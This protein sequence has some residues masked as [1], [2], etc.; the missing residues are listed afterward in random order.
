MGPYRLEALLG[1]GAMG[2]VY[3]ATDGRVG[4]AVALK[5]PLAKAESKVRERLQREGLAAASLDHPHVLKVHDLGC[6]PE[7][8]WYLA[9]ELV[10][11]ARSFE[12]AALELPLRRRVELVRDAA[13]G[14]GHAHARGVVHRDVKADNL[15]LDAAG[16][17][18]VADFGLAK[19]SD[20]ERLTQSGA[21]VGT[22]RTMSPEQATG[23]LAAVGPAS[24]VWSLGVVLYWALSGGSYPF[25]GS[26]L[27]ELM[28]RICHARP[29]KLA[30]TPRALE[31]VC[32]RAL[33]RDPAARYPDGAALA[34]DLDAWLEGRVAPSP[35]RRLVPAAL[36]LLSALALGAAALWAGLRD[37][38]PPPASPSPSPS[39]Q[40]SASA[41]AWPRPAATPAWFASLRDPPPLPLPAPVRFGETPG[42]FV[43]ERDASPLVW[44]APASFRRGSDEEGSHPAERPAHRVTLTRGFFLGRLEV[45][46]A[47]WREF[48]RRA[49]YTQARQVALGWDPDPREPATLVSWADAQA[50]CRWAG[51]RL[52]TEAEWELAATGGDQ[53]RFPW[54]SQ[55]EE[56]RACWGGRERPERVGSYPRGAAPSGALD[57]CGNVWEWVADA[58]ADYPRQDVRDPWVEDGPT[59]VIRGGSHDSRRE[60]CRTGKRE[61]LPGGAMSP[62]T[63]FRLCVP[64]PAR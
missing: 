60:V 52:P 48:C 29:P 31:A 63:G 53:R 41:P 34:A 22:P 26:N 8:Q 6:T 25:G 36:G 49:P 21:V 54:G 42:E 39:L 10:E 64:L 40:A 38:P 23:E 50:Y 13:Q 14:L 2:A 62:N 44:V 37:A 58:W 45:T 51:G 61:S 7:G 30:D 19:L 1:Q 59:R 47:Q 11:G 24:D 12:D 55:L 43:D 32:L 28:A 4:R 16:R 15:L 27:I 33:E 18:R 46:V 5:L 3:R 35:T 9:Y 20:V 17:L 57:L 56:G